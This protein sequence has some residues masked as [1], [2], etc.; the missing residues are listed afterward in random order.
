MPSGLFY[1]DSLGWP[2][3]NK[4]DVWL[5]SVATSFSRNFCFKYREDSDQMPCSLASNLGLHR[6]QRPFL[7]DDMHKCVYESEDILFIVWKQNSPECSFSIPAMYLQF[8]FFVFR[9]SSAA[10]VVL[11]RDSHGKHANSSFRNSQRWEIIITSPTG[12]FL[13]KTGLPYNSHAYT[14]STR[15]MHTV[16]LAHLSYC[17]NVRHASCNLL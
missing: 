10:F 15:T 5:I 12:L 14:F 8:G 1:T 11:T 4:R 3:S 16:L 13:S 6:L 9:F 2:I 17:V 7:W